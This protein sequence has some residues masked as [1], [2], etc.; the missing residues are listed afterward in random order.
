MRIFSFLFL[1]TVFF[2]LSCAIQPAEEAV[3]D[4]TAQK[5]A[6][7]QAINTVAE[8]WDEADAAGDVDALMSLV[9]DDFIR[10]EPNKPAIVGKEAFRES[11]QQ[12]SND[13]YSLQDAKDVIEE[14]RLAGDWAYVRGSW[15]GTV[16]LKAGGDP[17][18]VTSKWMDIRERQKDGSWKISRASVNED[19]P[20]EF[21][22]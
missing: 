22:W 10:M 12:P 9:T 4:D 3:V 6:D 2:A 16:V 20:L 5:E 13:E 21:N 8:L 15:S 17:I 18:H 19:A 1:G 11:L 7:I 14:I